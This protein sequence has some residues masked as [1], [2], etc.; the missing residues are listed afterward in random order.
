MNNEPRKM[1]P[2]EAE[3][4]NEWK[5][6]VEK[7]AFENDEYEEIDFES[8]WRKYC[9]QQ[10]EAA[11]KSKAQEKNQRKN[12]E[13]QTKKRRNRR[14]NSKILGKIRYAVLRRRRV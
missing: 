9:A 5:I 14:G 4:F 12:R 13:P 6:M 11:E 1:D 7:N 2:K 10:V 8:E 3:S